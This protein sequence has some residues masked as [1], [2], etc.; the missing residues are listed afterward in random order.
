MSKT[1]KK[2]PIEEGY[3]FIPESPEQPAYLLGSYSPAADRHFWPR[4]KLCPI[5]SEEVEDCDL[6]PDGV[7]HSW[8]FVEMPWMG[9]M[10]TADG[11]GYGVGQIDLP[12][13][14]RIQAL[15]DGE[16]GDWKIGMPMVFAPRT[17]AQDDD[18]NDLCTIAFAQQPE[19]GGHS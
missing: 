16:M 13:G 6:S 9:S 4:R 2:I 17:V 3:F 1:S 15:L 18:G 14:V 19:T 5:T 7:L 12:E 8:T 11:G 10:K